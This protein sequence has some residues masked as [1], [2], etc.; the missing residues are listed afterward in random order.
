MVDSTMMVG[1]YSKG[2]HSVLEDEESG[3][4]PRL[5]YPGLDLATYTFNQ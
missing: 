5:L 2:S 4:V 3:G 1:R